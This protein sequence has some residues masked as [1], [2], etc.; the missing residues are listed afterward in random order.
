MPSIHCRIRRLDNKH[1]QIRKDTRREQTSRRLS[2]F[3]LCLADGGSTPSCSAVNPLLYVFVNDNF[4]QNC[5]LAIS[6][7][8]RTASQFPVAVATHSAAVR[9]KSGLIADRAL[10]APSAAVAAATQPSIPHS[11]SI[12]NSAF[13]PPRQQQQQQQQPSIIICSGTLATDLPS[14]TQQQ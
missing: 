9:R 2:F 1:P 3:R 12:S 11:S 4:R 5:L 14:A 10:E 13:C 7:P 8:S 6:L